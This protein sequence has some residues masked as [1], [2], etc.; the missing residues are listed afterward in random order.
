MLFLCGKRAVTSW[1]DLLRLSG[2]EVTAIYGI[3]T[4]N[5]FESFWGGFK[6]GYWRCLAC[7]G[8]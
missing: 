3:P 7:L 5:L 6:R 8:I 2:Q 4:E 1:G